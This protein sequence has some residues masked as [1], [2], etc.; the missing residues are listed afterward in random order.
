MANEE[1][2]LPAMSSSIEDRSTAGLI[3]QFY[4]FKGSA[5]P[6]RFLFTHGDEWSD[7]APEVNDALRREFVGG[8]TSV[9][10]LITGSSYLF[11]FLQM[12]QIDVRTGAANPIAW[13]DALGRCFFPI[14]DGQRIT[15]LTRTGSSSPERDFSDASGEI[16]EEEAEEVEVVSTMASLGRPRWVGAE[17]IGE[18]DRDFK[19]IEKWFLTGYR[20]YVPG[21]VVTAIHRCSRSGFRGAS[22]LKTFQLQMQMT[23]AARGGDANVKLGWYGASAMDVAAIV[24]HGFG[25]PQNARPDAEVGGFG[26]HLSA[27]PY[28][29]L[30][31]LPAEEANSGDCEEKH[32]VL[33]KII[34][35]RPEKVEA[36]S[37]QY[38]R[39]SDEFDIGVDNVANPRRYVVWSTLMNTHVF[40]D[41]IV[42]YKI[43]KQQR[44]QFAPRSATL[45]QELLLTRLLAELSRSIPSSA[46]RTLQNT[47]KQFQERKMS[48]AAF[49][50]SIRSMV[51]DKLLLLAMRKIRGH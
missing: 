8:R 28:P 43:P 45:P 25:K 36:G 2:F 6:S 5:V 20:R 29:Y 1:P 27:A 23:K 4:K 47:Y 48:K 14:E 17:T 18:G 44:L 49:I 31:D 19:L 51:D 50:R 11:D 13:I 42:S 32:M 21:V 37:E 35:G 34:V 39:S 24:S 26:L 46:L 30:S 22:R 40:A 10:I 9:E 41:A 16:E 7:F 3:R 33:C 12:S 15:P 38:H